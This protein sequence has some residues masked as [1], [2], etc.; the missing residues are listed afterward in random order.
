M[1]NRNTTGKT[2]SLTVGVYFFPKL[3]YNGLCFTRSYTSPLRKGGHVISLPPHSSVIPLQ[4]IGIGR[5][6]PEYTIWQMEELHQEWPRRGMQASTPQVG[7]FPWLRNR[8]L[9]KGSHGMLDS[10]YTPVSRFST[11]SIFS[12][13]LCFTKKRN[14]KNS[15]LVHVPL[16]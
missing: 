13:P 10:P 14:I 2:Q 5:S 4:V 12:W 3:M 1:G 11:V 7:A 8:R 15:P 16:L 6:L 9:K